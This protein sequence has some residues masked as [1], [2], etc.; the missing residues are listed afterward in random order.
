[1]ENKKTRWF[2][3]KRHAYCDDCIMEDDVRDGVFDECPFCQSECEM[4]ELD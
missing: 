2:K 3:C 1:M 4:E